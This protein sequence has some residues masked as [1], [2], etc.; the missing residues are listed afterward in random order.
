VAVFLFQNLPALA[1]FFW[2]ILQVEFCQRGDRKMTLAE[3][4]QTDFFRA[5]FKRGDD[6]ARNGTGL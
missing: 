6:L 3:I 2:C 5:S 4:A 1:H